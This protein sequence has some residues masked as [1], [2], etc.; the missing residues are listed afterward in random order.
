[1]SSRRKP[2]QRDGFVCIHCRMPI[3][4]CASGT[5]HR[6]HCPLCLWSRHVDERVGDRRSACRA[7]MEPIGIDVR[8]D[9]EWALIHR[10]TGCGVIRTNR[11]AGDDQ[12]LALLQLALRPLAR[13]PFP[14]DH[15]PLLRGADRASRW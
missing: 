9:G 1:M 3:D 8:S 6:N 2:R 11:I 10:C 14:L 7:P 12:E 15:L 4:G 13:P 5:K